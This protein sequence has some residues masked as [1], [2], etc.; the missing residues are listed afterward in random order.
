MFL[1]VSYGWSLSLAVS[2]VKWSGYLS[3]T[4]YS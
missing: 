3:L 1:T 4:V 2:Q